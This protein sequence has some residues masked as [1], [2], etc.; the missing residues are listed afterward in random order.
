VD[1]GVVP[2]VD[3][4]ETFWEA[5]PCCKNGVGRAAAAAV[6]NAAPWTKTG[7]GTPVTMGTAKPGF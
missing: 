1:A 3:G 2:K 7:N 6:L 4:L 5:N